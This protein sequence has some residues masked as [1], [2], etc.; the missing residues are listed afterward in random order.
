MITQK[1]RLS[2]L[3]FE[4]HVYNYLEGKDKCFSAY[5]INGGDTVFIQELID[6]DLL[7]RVTLLVQPERQ[8]LYEVRFNNIVLYIAVA[9]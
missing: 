6:H 5:G 2:S 1:E 7:D 8:F 4:H 3:I 9:Q